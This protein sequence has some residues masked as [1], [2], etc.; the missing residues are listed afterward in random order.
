MVRV[1]RRTGGSWSGRLRAEYVHFEGIA[2]NLEA[3]SRKEP[4]IR[5]TAKKGKMLCLLF[6]RSSTCCVTKGASKPESQGEL[7]LGAPLTPVQALVT[8]EERIASATLL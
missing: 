8:L 2:V 7:V 4:D 3:A 5:L 6:E 1:D